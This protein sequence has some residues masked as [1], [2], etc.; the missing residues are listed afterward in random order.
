MK[1]SKHTFEVDN[2]NKCAVIVAHPDDETLWAGGTILLHPEAKWMV[3]TLCRRSDSDRSVKFFKAMESL[4]ASGLMGGL[5][6][7]PDQIPLSAEVVEEAIVGLLPSDRFDLI[8]THSTSGEY[9]R[10]L[11][12][13]ETAKAVLNLWSSN[14]LYA[15]QVWCFAY[16]DGDKRYLPQP[17]QDADFLV[18]LPEHIWQQKYGIITE[19]YGFSRDSFEARTTP[20]QEAFWCFKQPLT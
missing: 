5:D 2:F 20:R 19:I 12:H 14:R 9:T 4:N 3:V 1:Q 10:H 8:I 7:G 13:E 18:E 11:R 16:E 6:D 15:K 17:V